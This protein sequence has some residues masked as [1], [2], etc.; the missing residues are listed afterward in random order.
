MTAHDHILKEARKIDTS[1]PLEPQEPGHATLVAGPS[2]RDSSGTDSVRRFVRENPGPAVL[3]GAGLAWLFVN[4]ERARS[5]S[6]PTRIKD[7]AEHIKEGAGHL[8]EATSEH[9]DKARES[10]SETLHQA[11]ESTQKSLQHA[12][13][14]TESRAQAARDMAMQKAH[15]VQDLANEKALVVKRRY[16][17][18]LD[19]NPL[20]LGAG[21]LIAGLCLGL[22]LPSTQRENELLGETRDSL[23]DQ[24][25]A[26]V[27]EAR[28]AAVN[29]LKSSRG[30]VEEKLLEAKDEM[31]DAVQESLQEAKEAA[32]DEI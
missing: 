7:R 16:R 27:H 6:L 14:A 25:R 24:A 19:E 1:Q 9:L 8:K 21:A 31:A 30:A 28:T 17:T 3:I 4:R 18:M 29:S 15:A 23:M 5:R 22:L 12:L 20:A 2:A 10:T 11:K 26:I 32:R 13:E